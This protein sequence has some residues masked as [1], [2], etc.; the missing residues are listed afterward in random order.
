MTRD[1]S[2]IFADDPLGLLETSPQRRSSSRKERQRLKDGFAEI[3]EFYEE[4]GREPA[5]S[6]DLKEYLLHARL[7]S[8]RETPSKVAD[9]TSL[10]L[11]DLLDESHTMLIPLEMLVSD[12]PLGILDDDGDEGIFN[13]EHVKATSRMDP[14]Y[15]AHRVVCQDYGKYKEGFDT[16]ANELSL[17]KRHLIEFTGTEVAPGSYYVL[18]GILMLLVGMD[19]DKRQSDFSSGSRERLDGRTRCIFDNGTES[20]MLMRSLVK[21]LRHSNEGFEVSDVIE[22]GGNAPVVDAD[23]VQNGY[24]YVLSSKSKQPDIASMTN[25]YKIGFSSG[26]VTERV[27]NAINEPTYL[28]APVTIL[29]SVRCFNVDPYQIEGLLHAF[30]AE[31]NVSIAVFTPDG[32]EHHPRE[33]FSVPLDV[34]DGA[35]ELLQKNDIADY[36]YDPKLGQIVERA[37]GQI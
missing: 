15:V 21:A 34:I 6:G 5:G 10:D 29:R 30:F 12:D 8:I 31:A 25:L 18:N 1:F 22:N 9:L 37:K 35:L 7:K 36:R 13:L 3:V 20:T 26:D 19:V 23:D 17:R 2:D 28:M 11:Y 33:W 16:V 24:I 4:N 14:D 32:I 27:K